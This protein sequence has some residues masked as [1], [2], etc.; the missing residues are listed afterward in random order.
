MPAQRV[1]S[2]DMEPEIFLKDQR[3][4]VSRSITF[5]TSHRMPW[6]A[7]LVPNS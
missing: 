3:G 2:S 6:K 7:K 1:S 5:D 4:V